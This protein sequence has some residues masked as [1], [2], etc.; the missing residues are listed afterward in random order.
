MFHGAELLKPGWKEN[1]HFLEHQSL[2]SNGGKPIKG[3]LLVIHGD[4]DPR[5]SYETVE[6]AV[7]KMAEMFP[8]AQLEFVTLP[9]VTHAPALPASQ[10]LWMDWIADR[11]EGREVQPG[12]KR[13]ELARARPDTAYQKE[14]NWYLEGASTFYHAP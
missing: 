2:T 11:F 10:R 3:P 5:L 13:S 6:R 8:L 12:V 4:A 14:Q 9:N 1:Q 7:Q